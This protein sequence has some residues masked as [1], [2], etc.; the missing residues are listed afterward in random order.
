MLRFLK[1]LTCGLGG[2][3]ATLTFSSHLKVLH[4]HVNSKHVYCLIVY[5]IV[6]TAMPRHAVAAV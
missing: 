4:Y 2:Q 3:L 1:F 6:V 5:C